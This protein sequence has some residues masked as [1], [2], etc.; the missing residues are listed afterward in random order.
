MSKCVIVCTEESIISIIIVNFPPFL[1]ES[2]ALSEE[3]VVET[4]LKLGERVEK[5][6]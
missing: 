4:G 6:L 1:T 3:L 5:A 2:S